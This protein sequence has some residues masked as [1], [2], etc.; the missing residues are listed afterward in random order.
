MSIAGTDA[1]DARTAA[2]PGTSTSTTDLPVYVAFYDAVCVYCDRAVRQLIK[3]DKRQLL[4]Y[5]PLQGDTAASLRAQWP[6]QFPE[7]RIASMVFFDRSG[8]EPVLHLRAAG[9]RRIFE[10][11]GVA[12]DKP[13][14]L[15]RTPRWLADLGYRAFAATRYRRFGK[16]DACKLPD[17]ELAH[18]FL[19]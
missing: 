11:L 18:L 10:V 13:R 6:K 4:R 2:A 12:P 19:P 3:A 8:G 5:A 17:P 16:Y 1:S 9:I 7:G 15:H 14:W